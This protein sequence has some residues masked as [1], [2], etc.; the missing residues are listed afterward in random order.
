VHV[1]KVA[2]IANFGAFVT[3]GPG[4]DGLLHISKLGGAKRLKHPGEA[5]HVGQPVE[6]RVENVD[7]P[8][9][10]LSLALAAA[11]AEAT[12]AEVDF[13]EYAEP[14]PPEVGMLG[15]LLKAKLAEKGKK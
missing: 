11:E 4:V 15:E 8:G 5:L 2:R 1:G 3:L 7:V 9:R 14:K 12:E 10:R 13:A 6:V